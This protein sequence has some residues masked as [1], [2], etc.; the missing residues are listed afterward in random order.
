MKTK[1]ITPCIEKYTRLFF[2]C[3]IISNKFFDVTEMLNGDMTNR[4]ANCND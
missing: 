2:L 1:K 3:F 4:L